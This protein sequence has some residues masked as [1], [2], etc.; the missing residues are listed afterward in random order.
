MTK[1]SNPREW[2]IWFGSGSGS[3]HHQ[4]GDTGTPW[5]IGEIVTIAEMLD[6]DDIVA[7]YEEKMW[8]SGYFD[9]LPFK[10]IGP[11]LEKHKGERQ[12]EVEEENGRRM[13]MTLLEITDRLQAQRARYSNS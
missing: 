6:P 12:W 2:L 13:Y 9:N 1:I 4:Y 10:V 3:P 7:K 5:W 11:V 8:E